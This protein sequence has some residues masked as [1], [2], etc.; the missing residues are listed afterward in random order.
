MLN[1]FFSQLFQQRKLVTFLFVAVFSLG[2]YFATKL[3]IDA[4]PDITGV[5]VVV[6]AKTGALDPQQIE[7]AVT[8][9]IET[10]MAG[11]DG[12]K[13]VRSISKYGLSQV[14]M[15]F[16]DDV[17]LYRARQQ[18]S[19]R[20]QNVTTTLPDN[21]NVAMGPV[22]TG[23]GEVF[24]YVLS[25]E[26]GSDLSRK[27][28]H[29]RLTYLRTVQDYFI[30]PRLKMI[31]GVAD[32]DSNGGFK[33]EVHVNFYPRKMARYG[34]T[35]RQVISEL[36]TSGSNF[37]GGYIQK[38]K[39]QVIVRMNNQLTDHRKISEFPIKVN[40]LGNII[41]V[42]DIA[43]VRIESA[44]RLGAATFNSN[45][46]V[47]GTGLM[48]TGA[49]S[50]AVAQ[51]LEKTL[52]EM[53][54]PPM[55]RA[56]IVYNRSYLVNATVATITRNLAE[57]A[58]LVILVLFLLIG[59]YRAA[60]LVALAIPAS[61]LIAAIG[62][63]YFNI[64]ANLMSLGALD[65]GLLV[66]G[67]VVLIADYISR[68]SMKPTTTKEER[69]NVMTDSLGEVLKPVS[70][71]LGMI[72][73]VYAPILALEGI[74]GKM[75][76]PMAVTVLMALAASLLVAIVLLPVIAIL[77]IHPPRKTGHEPAF[78]RFVSGLYI[79]ILHFALRHKIFVTSGALVFAVASFFLFTRIGS[80]FIPQLDEGDLVIG[81]SRSTDMSLNESI[82]QQ[83]M[84][85]KIIKSFKE[86]ELVFSR[87]GTPESAT[88][89]MSVN[90]A[91]TFVILKKDRSLWPVVNGQRRTKERLFKDI[92]AELMKL[93]SDQEVSPT[94]PIEMRFNEMLEGSR[95]DITV[96]LI[97]PD[98]DKLLL[99]LEKTRKIIETIPGASSVEQDP[100]TTL[101]KSPVL[102]FE[103]DH[104][105]I[106]YYGLT[107][108]EV[109]ETLNTAMAGYEIGNYYEDNIRFPIKLHL[110]ESLRENPSQVSNIP[111]PLEEGASI[112]LSRVTRVSKTS[113]VTTIAHVFG[114]RYAAISIYIAG[115]DI[116]SFVEE[117]RARVN[118]EL[119]LPAEYNVY[120]GGQFKN[121]A[122]ARLR[123]ALI[124]PITLGLILLIL[125]KNFNNLK[126]ALIVFLGIP[127][128]ATG[129]VLALYFSGQNFSVSAAIG[130]IALSGIATLNAMVLFSHFL[131]LKSHGVSGAELVIQGTVRR[132]R[133]V[134]MTAMVASLGFLPMAVNTGLGSEVQRP[135][136]TVVVGGIITSTALTLLVLPILYLVF[137]SKEAR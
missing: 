72:M 48:R 118:K 70:L 92:Q 35:L 82:D 54:L 122:S 104:N 12:L 113:Q 99:Y 44:Q 43:E 5:Q 34:V 129:G 126:D 77:V 14:T 57:G 52:K 103:L 102:D 61:M 111:I 95:A 119:K 45:E 66:D 68:L 40:A 106:A 32:V 41:R 88:D 105:A 101:T 55:V 9:Q 36:E 74:E 136:A 7:S 16:K 133:P 107:M 132:F 2:A 115:R 63:H 10:E 62:M 135:L 3:S 98:L 59:N 4:V 53:N 109:N 22:T 65:F 39:K 131:Y 116:D 80:D 89:P 47:L 64:S 15:V 69:W 112:E 110:D 100:L 120:W 85:E 8:Y 127:F 67:S 17:D 114:K 137:R 50:Q 81:M 13:E 1:K 130:F 33:K 97:G 87:L 134:L 123:L 93:N 86:V 94:Q 73:L 29:E 51:E 19:E 71:G 49:N 78:Y 11:I 125:Y 21:V 91:D 27:N 90:L 76:H 20:L 83:L 124:I 38:D 84:A 60:I 121:L 37:G 26:P 6:N 30:R 79:P 31:E 24:M 108:Q 96:R 56:E 42:K 23:L 25:A 28:K 18:V 75:F 128:A 117:A 58:M 46:T